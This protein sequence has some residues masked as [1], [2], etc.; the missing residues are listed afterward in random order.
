MGWSAARKLRK[1]IEGL[2]QVLAIELLTAAS[3]IQLRAPLEPATATKRSSHT[4]PGPGPDRFLA[5]EIA[6][7]TEFVKSGGAREAAESITGELA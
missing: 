2:T 7:A 1:A 6:Q 5:P 4:L 3:G